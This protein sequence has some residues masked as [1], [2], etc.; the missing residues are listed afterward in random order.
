MSQLS[1][2]SI[3]LFEFLRQKYSKLH[4]KIQ[5]FWKYVFLMV[6]KHCV[7]HYYFVMMSWYP[8]L[9]ERCPWLLSYTPCSFSFHTSFGPTLFLHYHLITD[10]NYWIPFDVDI[11]WVVVF[12][13]SRHFFQLF[14]VL[15]FLANVRDAFF[16]YFKKDKK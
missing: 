1:A 3:P 7:V 13:F 11:T 8:S 10:D 12:I 6:F 2:F 16:R 14:V 4:T 9:V 5:T 15:I